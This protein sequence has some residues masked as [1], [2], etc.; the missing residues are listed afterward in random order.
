[1]PAVPRWRPTSAG[2]TV[3]DV[4]E[5]HA[6]LCP[7]PE[8]AEFMHTVLLPRVTAGRDLGRHLLEI[9]PGPGAT[10]EW[11]RHRVERLTAV[12]LEPEAAKK[13]RARFAGTNVEVID[14]DASALGFGDDTFD[15]VG[16]FTMLHHV[17]TDRLQNAI[18]A[19]VLRVLRPG[20][21]FVGSDSLA[22]TDLHDF[23]VDDIY[24]PIEPSTMLTRLRTIGF[25]EVSVTAAEGMIFAGTKAGG[26]P[27]PASS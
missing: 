4:N 8:W 12:E 2:P 1:M 14:G 16:C 17:P 23:H 26:P 21:V 13:L 25:D 5:N 11:L 3:F 6:K 24:N 19:E 7:S 20:G 9:G 27:P 22:S 15:S 10:T 18:F